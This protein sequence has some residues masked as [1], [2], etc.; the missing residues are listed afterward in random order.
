MVLRGSPLTAITI[1]LDALEQAL[2][3][4]SDID[5]QIHHRD[6]GSQ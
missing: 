3:A 6:H 1:V 2:R 4:R 5:G